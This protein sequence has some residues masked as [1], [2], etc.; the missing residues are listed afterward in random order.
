MINHGPGWQYLKV[1]SAFEFVSE[2]WPKF[3]GKKVWR[4]RKES[5]KRRGQSEAERE[6]FVAVTKNCEGTD[7]APPHP[8]PLSDKKVWKKSLHTHH[9]WV[10]DLKLFFAIQVFLT[11]KDVKILLPL[12]CSVISPA[13]IFS[14]ASSRCFYTYQEPILRLYVEFTTPITF[15]YGRKIMFIL[16]SAL[17]Y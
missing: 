3:R 2:L 8:P 7:R 9:M 6:E 15:L 1:R 14:S 12:S 17:S 4:K 11:N 16:K 10:D 5:Y 13:T